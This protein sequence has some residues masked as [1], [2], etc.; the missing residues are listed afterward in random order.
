MHPGNVVLTPS[1]WHHAYDAD[2]SERAR[3][4]YKPTRRTDCF[5]M[6]SLGVMRKG[7]SPAE[8]AMRVLQELGWTP[9][10]VDD[11]ASAS[12]SDP[13][14]AEAQPSPEAIGNEHE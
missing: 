14:N 2:G 8:H 10:P 11:A 1:I 13:A 12:G 3:I 6:L 7:E 9:P 4:S 5:A